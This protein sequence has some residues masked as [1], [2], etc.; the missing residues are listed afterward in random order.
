MQTAHRRY[1]QTNQAYRAAP[2]ASE[3]GGILI[4]SAI[5]SLICLAALVYLAWMPFVTRA[6]LSEAKIIN[7]SACQAAIQRA[8]L[9]SLMWDSFI[10]RSKTTLEMESP[11]G[12]SWMRYADVSETELFLATPEDSETNE[13]NPPAS[14]VNWRNSQ[15]FKLYT[16]Y[17]P[18]DTTSSAISLLT[19]KSVLIKLNTSFREAPISPFLVNDIQNMGNTVVCR[20]KFRPRLILFGSAIFDLSESETVSGFTNVVQGVNTSPPRPESPAFNEQINPAS[21]PGISIAIAP[22]FTEA[23]KSVLAET[24]ALLPK[25][26]GSFRFPNPQIK[27]GSDYGD[28]ALSPL[29]QIAK[30]GDANE[31]TASCLQPVALMRN[32]FLATLTELLARDGRFRRSTSILSVNSRV[33]GGNEGVILPPTVIAEKGVD[34]KSGSFRAPYSLI[35]YRLF[36]DSEYTLPVN[37][38]LGNFQIGS[39]LSTA[40]GLTEDRLLSLG[41]LAHCTHIYSDASRAFST[42]YSTPKITEPENFELSQA[43]SINEQNRSWQY[44]EQSGIPLLPL[45]DVLAQLGTV[46]LC[47]FQREGICSSPTKV[48]PDIEGLSGAWLGEW[49]G[50]KSPGV[51]PPQP[52]NSLN[53]SSQL[54]LRSEADEIDINDTLILVAH[55][56]DTTFAQSLVEFYSKRPNLIDGTPIKPI[57]IVLF[58]ETKISKEAAAI[59]TNLTKT[60]PLGRPGL[61]SIISIEPCETDSF[62]TRIYPSICPQEGTTEYTDTLLLDFWNKMLYDPSFEKNIYRRALDFYREYLT[63]TVQLL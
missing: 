46:R 18:A 9:T 4:A 49:T 57:R 11:N 8:P 21:L 13:I 28:L 2:G 26:G 3:R 60:E 47:P 15:T 50:L 62:G 51:Y 12:G 44:K 43:F 61:N 63:H 38:V 31:R 5:A 30:A 20:T 14:G 37:G 25:I 23:N 7:I 45:P 29:S 40:T 32:A 10:D 59:L 6:A 1:S 22:Q 39:Q 17:T 56:V 48:T 34:I 54:A 55:T 58:P 19:G 27:E 53:Q 24:T 42:P 33:E 41:Q 52:T 16:T 35:S 36:R